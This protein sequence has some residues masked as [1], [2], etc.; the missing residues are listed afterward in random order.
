MVGMSGTNA[1][2]RQRQLSILSAVSGAQDEACRAELERCGGDLR[3]SLLCLLS[4]LAPDAAGGP[5]ADAGGSVRGALI[6]LGLG[7]PA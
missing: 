6:Q 3:L 1:K 2:L 7:E 4:G 5:L